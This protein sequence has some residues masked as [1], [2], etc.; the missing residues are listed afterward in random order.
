VTCDIEVPAGQLLTLEPG[1]VLQFEPNRRLIVNGTLVARGTVA[2]AI[3]FTSAS[4]TPALG[5]WNGIRV[6]GTVDI[7]YAEIAFAWDGIF[8]LP[9]S[10][11]SVTD[12]DFVESH[13]AVFLMTNVW[14]PFRRLTATG[15]GL[16]GIL[17]FEDYSTSGTL[18]EAGVPYLVTDHIE[19]EGPIVTIEPGV[20]FK[21]YDNSVQPLTF[22]GDLIAEGTAAKPIVFTALSDD[23]VAG[24]TN[25][26]G[27]ATSPIP[28]EW[29][30]LEL[31]G[32]TGIRQYQLRHLE[33]R[34]SHYGIKFRDI[35]EGSLTDSAF[36]DI[37]SC[38]VI[39][40]GVWWPPELSGLSATGCQGGNG[41]QIIVSGT[42]NEQT[43]A[44]GAG[45]PYIFKGA[46]QIGTISSLSTHQIIEP[47]TVFKFD[48]GASLDIKSDLSAH[49]SPG[50][51]IVFTS[52]KDDSVGG[53]TNGDGGATA[54]AQ[55]DWDTLGLTFGGWPDFQRLSHAEVKYATTGITLDGIEAKALTDV[56]IAHT[57]TGVLCSNASH[58][59]LDGVGLLQNMT[60]IGLQTNCNV[61]ITGGWISQAIIGL[62]CGAEVTVDGLDIHQGSTGIRVRDGCDAVVTGSD[63][64]GNTT[65]IVAF[66]TSA[67]IDLGDLSDLDLT[68]DGGNSFVCNITDV[69]NL[70]GIEV[71]AENNWWG[72]APPDDSTIVGPVDVDP[73]IAD[74]SNALIPD[75]RVFLDATIVHDLGV[76]LLWHNR[77]PSCGYRVWRSLAPDG[78]FTDISGH[79]ATASYYDLG[80]IS[81]PD[82][83]FYFIEI[84]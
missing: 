57:A 74:G 29:Y 48:D 38:P 60:G 2:Q 31:D 8:F 51:P 18:T 55:G 80:A 37:S 7:Q 20:I 42:F 67:G 14:V 10:G 72:E 19:F 40:D 6:Y 12:T 43:W 47:G 53:D 28:G 45:I 16:N 73:Y 22:T 26:D 59:T 66:G 41:V 64:V 81:T 36:S 32:V 24:D 76:R 23:T 17:I 9:G 27:D 82:S 39:L 44:A 63:L 68:N 13:Q 1:V 21:L 30:G 5:D 56:K 46:N 71:A 3:R 75:L 77:A 61:A 52:I 54:P 58:V 49:G 33:V 70:S 69:H 50:H 25:G 62:D 79:V 4:P 78:G 65:G 11:G 34:W 35:F 84:D 15:G 83:Y